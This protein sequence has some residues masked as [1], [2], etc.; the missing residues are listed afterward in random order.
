[1]SKP[2]EKKTT[3]TEA[4]K[5]M[6]ILENLREPIQKEENPDLTNFLE[7]FAKGKPLSNKEDDPGI[8]NFLQEFAKT[9]N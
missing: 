1:M 8:N 7:D 3:F 9:G 2:I 4:D 5:A 6:E